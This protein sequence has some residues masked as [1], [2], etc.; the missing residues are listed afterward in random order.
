YALGG[1][2]GPVVISLSIYTL[3]SHFEVNDSLI[4]LFW[5]IG[6]LGV[7]IS[8]ILLTKS[9]LLSL[10]KLTL[11]LL[12]LA[13]IS[14]GIII[15]GVSSNPIYYIIGFSLMTFGNPIINTLLSAQAFKAIPQNSK[16]KIMGV[17]EA[18]SEIGTLLFMAISWLL[19]SYS[20]I[21]FTLMIIAFL[22]TIRISIFYSSFF[23][24]ILRSDKSVKS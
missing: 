23:E 11:Y 6:G 14:G 22:A 19:I 8:N 2:I 13:L 5:L 10:S 7:I 16:A 12:S 4:S 21:F 3:E 24:V 1:M 9:N 15:M 20:G 18:S 17:M